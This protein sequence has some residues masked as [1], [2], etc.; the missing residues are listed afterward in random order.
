MVRAT[1]R[2]LALTNGAQVANAGI[3]VSGRQ[4]PAGSC[5]LHAACCVDPPQVA[6]WMDSGS[7]ALGPAHS[8]TLLFAATTAVVYRRRGSSSSLLVEH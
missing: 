7:P 8:A 3:R 1:G 4:A 2:P 5:V 6:D